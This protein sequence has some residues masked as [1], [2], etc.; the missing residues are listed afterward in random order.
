MLGKD[1]R[2]SH[3]LKCEFSA[4]YQMETNLMRKQLFVALTSLGLWA[5]FARHA[6]AQENRALE[7]TYPRPVLKAVE[8]LS[9]KYGY[10]ITYEEPKVVYSGD[11]QDI[12]QQR[13]AEA[14]AQ[15]KVVMVRR[16]LALNGGSVEVPLPT[17]AQVS[18]STMYSLLQQLVRSWTDSNQ[19]GA[20]FAVEEDGAIF[21]IVPTEVRDQNGNWQTVQS[22]LNVPISLATEA[23]TDLDT[24]KAIANAVAAQ[25][26]VRLRWVV[27]G[28][29]MIGGQLNTKRYVIG[30]QGEPAATVLM[31]AF[32]SMGT[33]RTWYLNYDPTSHT[34]V[35]NI[36]DVQP[37]TPANSVSPPA[38]PPVPMPSGPRVPCTSC[39]SAVTPPPRS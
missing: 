32:K 22:I 39:A 6:N 29:L 3:Q 8:D 18:V 14:K 35:L 36:D 2:N 11:V 15:G 34:Y 28:G 24:F 20:H 10:V 38:P 37:T 21:H 23:R 9:E 30:A 4:V 25:A 1:G 5:L 27:N 17:T 12:T 19:G 16:V 7:I 13:M 31:R 26:G 33:K